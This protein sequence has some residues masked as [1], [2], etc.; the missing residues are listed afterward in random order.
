M[1][2]LNN[3]NKNNSLF[4]FANYCKMNN[5]NQLN[6]NQADYITKPKP[7]ILRG[8]M[9]KPVISYDMI[10]DETTVKQSYYTNGQKQ[11]AREL[12]H[13]VY[14][15]IAT[16]DLHNYTRDS[17]MD[18]LIKFLATYSTPHKTCLKVIHGFGHNSANNISILKLS[19]RKYL[20]N[21]P[22][23]LAYSSAIINNGGD[24]VTL[25]KL[26]KVK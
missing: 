23:V 7:T 20:A 9:P 3:P 22:R 6:D 8:E 18:S 16:L 10:I 13:G 14:T 1:K 21:D 24:G 15:V 12:Y 19:V 5:I 2:K 26:K 4:S 25:I 11:I 17:A